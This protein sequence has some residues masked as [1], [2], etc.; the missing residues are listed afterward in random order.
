VTGGGGV[1]LD[2]EVL[3]PADVDGGAV[4]VDRVVSVAA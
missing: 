4:V 3:E 1:G 2:V